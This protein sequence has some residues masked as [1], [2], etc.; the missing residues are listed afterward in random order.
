M[1]WNGTFR[2]CGPLAKDFAAKLKR[3]QLNVCTLYGV[4]FSP[5][6]LKF[7]PDWPAISVGC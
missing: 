3:S 2:D 4:L 6:W 5:L 1:A 7:V